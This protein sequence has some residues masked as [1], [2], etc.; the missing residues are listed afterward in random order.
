M[1]KVRL[2]SRFVETV[3]TGSERESFRDTSVTGLELRV[4]AKGTKTWAIVYRRKSDGRRRRYTLG[5]FPAMSLDDARVA[6]KGALASIA[7]GADPAGGVQERKEALAFREL[8]EEWRIRHGQ[9]NKGW[10]SL[11]DNVSMLNRHILPEIGDMK[12][13]EITKRDLIRLFDK[14]TATPDAR[15]VK[16]GKTPRRTT[17]RTNRVFELVRS[18]FRWGVGRDI[19]S[20]DPTAGMS[21]PI[22]KEKPRDRALSFSEIATLWLALDNAPETK[23]AYG[24]GTFPMTKATALSLKIALA[25]GQRIG[26]VTGM[27][28]S[29]YNLEGDAPLWTVPARRSK[30]GEP[31]RVPLSPLAVR[32]FR[33]AEALAGKAPWL[34]PSPKLSKSGKLRGPIDAHA[35]TKALERARDKIAVASFRVHDLR[36]TAATRMAELGVSPH[37]IGMVLNHVSARA[38]TITSAVYVQYSYDKEKREALNIWGAALE[39]TAIAATGANVVEF[40]AANAP[41]LILSGVANAI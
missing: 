22:R 16:K 3:S 23:A 27:D 41:E 2:T 18:I 9:V 8:S 30:N 21:A 13:G 14:V 20:V 4:T 31:N 40:K 17:H 35:P 24:E 26:E 11:K 33:E 32:L 5:T 19:I 39:R 29:E 15:K 1:A 34:F 25:T 37:T 38:G 6:A 10:R 12:A 28:R 7:R 36:R